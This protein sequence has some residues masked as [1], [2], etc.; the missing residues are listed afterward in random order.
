MIVKC[1]KCSF[2]GLYHAKKL[3]FI[4]I[5][6][7]CA[8]CYSQAVSDESREIVQQAQRMDQNHYYLFTKK[9]VVFLF[10]IV[11]LHQPEV[12][13][14]LSMFVCRMVQRDASFSGHLHP[15]YGT[16]WVLFPFHVCHSVHGSVEKG[17][18][19]YA[20]T[21]CYSK[22]LTFFLICCKVRF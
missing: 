8:K 4:L 14:I 2:Y 9:N 3:I 22:L 6:Q 13:N 7:I 1:Y 19:S 5:L 12:F 20:C 10:K 11:A 18:Q 17:L 21:S 16:N 15:L